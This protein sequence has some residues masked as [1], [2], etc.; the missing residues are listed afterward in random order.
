[1]TLYELLLAGS[2]ASTTYDVETSFR[3][4]DRCISCYEGN[5]VLRPFA[6]SRT[7]M[8]VFQSGLNAGLGYTSWQLKKDGS[9]W[10]WVPLVA[11][12]GIHVAAATHNKGVR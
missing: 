4:F 10:W 2:I 8:Y 3:A 1:M 12:I 11:N 5:P 6:D 7:K 9:K